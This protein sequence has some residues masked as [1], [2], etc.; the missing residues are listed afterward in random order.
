MRKETE[1]TQGYQ[2]RKASRDCLGYRALQAL[3]EIRG[4]EEILEDQDHTACQEA[5]EAWGCQA[6]KGEKELQDFQV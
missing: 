4:A 3:E 6:L 5:W 1:A 2:V